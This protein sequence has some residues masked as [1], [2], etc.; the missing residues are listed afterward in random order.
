MRRILTSLALAACIAGPPQVPMQPRPARTET[1]AAESSIDG[2]DIIVKPYGAAAWRVGVKNET[3][4][5]VSIVWDE[6]TFVAAD[7][8]SGGRLIRGETRRMDVA[9]AQPATPVAPKSF[10]TEVVLVEKLT[11]IDKTES[12]YAEHNAKWGGISPG[13]ARV[14]G[15]QRSDVAKIISGSAINVTVQLA[16]GKKTWTGRVSK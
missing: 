8:Q 15:E 16:D 11:G 7:G 2:L 4:A 3:D 1:V 12:D 10:V 13:M 14:L 9:K 6:S 5:L